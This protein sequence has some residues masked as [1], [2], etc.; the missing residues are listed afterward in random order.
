M[1]VFVAGGTG[2]VGRSLCAVL[3]DRGHAVTA[4]SRS[5]DPSGLPPGV[6]TAAV[7]VTDPDH[8]S[9]AVAGHDAVVNLVALPS[10]VQ[11]RGRSHDAVHRG[12][13]RNLVR[14]CGERGVDRFVQISGLGVDGGAH[15]AYFAAKRRAER[16]V[17]RSDLEWVVYRPSVVFGDGCAI[18][19]FVRSVVPPGVAFL[20]G[21]GDAMRL[22]PLW[23]GDLAPMLADGVTDARHVGRVYRLGGPEVLTLAELAR[24]VRRVR[25]VVPVPLPAAAVAFGA[26]ELLPWVPFGLD[27]YRVLRLDNTVADNDVG[28]FGVDEAAMLRLREYL[29]R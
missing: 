2:F 22:Q 29:R 19:P 6:D 8:L 26:A 12:G 17:R 4:A 23:V 18:L 3:A 20:P 5:P 27:Q 24:L 10:H 16:L 25:L 13:T 14:A 21:G 15:T 11:P 28:A 9:D 1:N 7:D